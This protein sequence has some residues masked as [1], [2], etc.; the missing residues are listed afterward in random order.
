MTFGHYRIYSDRSWRFS[1]FRNNTK[2]IDPSGD[3]YTCIVLGLIVFQIR[4]EYSFV[5]TLELENQFTC[6]N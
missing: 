1:T 4:L 6:K 3:G 5:V 2:I